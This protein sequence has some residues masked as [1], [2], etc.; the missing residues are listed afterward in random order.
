MAN[1]KQIDLTNL[2]NEILP[3]PSKKLIPHRFSNSGEVKMSKCN[4]KCMS[5]ACRTIA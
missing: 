2:L 4:G 3:I 1:I 5:G